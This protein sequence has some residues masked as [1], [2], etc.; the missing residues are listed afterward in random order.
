MS[1]KAGKGGTAFQLPLFSSRV[2]IDAVPEDPRALPALRER[3]A[4]VSFRAP[5]ERFRADPTRPAWKGIHLGTGSGK[6]YQAAQLTLPGIDHG[7]LMIIRTSTIALADQF[8][9]LAKQALG[10]GATV[11]RSLARED[12]FSDDVILRQ[13][14]EALSELALLQR[15]DPRLWSLIAYQYAGRKRAEPKRLEPLLNEARISIERFKASLESLPNSGLD[16]RD[17][18]RLIGRRRQHVIKVFS[19]LLQAVARVELEQPF[20]SKLAPTTGELCSRTFPIDFALF[21]KPGAVVMT[22]SKFQTC[23]VLATRGERRPGGAKSSLPPTHYELL[24]DVNTTH[25]RANVLVI[26][27]EEEGYAADFNRLSSTV[28]SPQTWLQALS[29]LSTFCRWNMFSKASGVVDSWHHLLF[30]RMQA[31]LDHVGAVERIVQRLRAGALKRSEARAELVELLGLTKSP[32][33]EALDGLLDWLETA[34]RR[35]RPQRA[36]E[37]HH[38]QFHGLEYWAL[39]WRSTLMFRAFIRKHGLFSD[40]PTELERWNRF[41]EAVLNRSCLVVTQATLAEVGE[42]LMYLFFDE[43]QRLVEHAMLKH[44]YVAAMLD[45]A[46]L[47]LVYRPGGRQAPDLF[48]LDVLLR[49][50]LWLALVVSHRQFKLPDPSDKSGDEPHQHELRQIHEL[51]KRFT[52]PLPAAKDFDDLLDSLEAGE[53]PVVDDALM[54]EGTKG[55]LTLSTRPQSVHSEE[56]QIALF[57]ASVLVGSPEAQVRTLL[58]ATEGGPSTLGYLMS[59]TSGIGGTFEYDRA[60]LRGALAPV[61]GSFEG[62][63]DTEGEITQALRSRASRDVEVG[64]FEAQNVESRMRVAAGSARRLAELFAVPRECRDYHES[65]FKKDELHV[66]LCALARLAEADGPHAGMVFA[67]SVR[68]VAAALDNAVKTGLS[69]IRRLDGPDD[70]IYE[71]DPRACLLDVSDARPIVVVIYRSALNRSALASQS[72]PE[73]GSELDPEGLDAAGAA[74]PTDE[75]LDKLQRRLD[76]HSDLSR[77]KVLFVSAYLSAARGLSLQAYVDQDGERRPCGYNFLVVANHRYYDRFLRRADARGGSAEQLWAALKHLRHTGELGFMTLSDVGRE[78]CSRPGELL[79]QAAIVE[80]FESHIQA[81]GRLDRGHDLPKLQQIFMSSDCVPDLIE[82]SRLA[83]GFLRR[84]VKPPYVLIKAAEDYALE[85]SPTIADFD[86]HCEREVAV[87]RHFLDG[88]GRWLHGLEEERHRGRS[89][90]FARVWQALRDLDAITDP[91]AF[92]ARLGRADSPLSARDRREF[93][94]YA[95]FDPR[96]FGGEEAQ[97]RTIVVGQ[98]SRGEDIRIVADF[99]N[100]PT[101]T[102]YDPAQQLFDTYLLSRKPRCDYARLCARLELRPEG[103]FRELLPRPLYTTNFLKAIVAEELTRAALREAGV[104]VLSDE[105]A[106]E[107]CVYEYLDV[108]IRL[109]SGRLV[110]ID[111]KH[112]MLGTD[113][114]QKKDLLSRV[115]RKAE[116]VCKRLDEPVTFRYMNLFGGTLR[117]PQRC[118]R[119]DIQFIGLFEKQSG[120]YTS[121]FKDIFDAR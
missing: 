49:L 85:R 62:F 118:D 40:A 99:I 58:N 59:A 88:V 105:W 92:I 83:D 60:Y 4:A 22:H 35:A 28:T 72:L 57:S 74:G 14:P 27:E 104:Q 103:L 91:A 117:P 106:L 112:W 75:E 25:H 89:N 107:H 63:T 69:G 81:T 56:Y 39:C 38:A 54:F 78:L 31:L 93:I 47:E 98:D 1:S 108:F 73:E 79:R 23:P 46:A 29:D 121:S 55:F 95:Y 87:T 116:A 18:G 101:G 34:C 111:S 42:H 64:F 120:N 67:L 3:M 6:T 109:R 96:P 114:R 13:A 30:D 97:F 26:D 9:S 11:Y 41:L 80:H 8:Q 33:R 36:E 84:A 50:L 76:R 17:A 100:A 113:A 24:R 7:S 102:L 119:Y 20:T 70:Q 15:R 66:I 2:V 90:L 16:P 44:I 86:A 10:S 77:N 48:D 115:P 43:R 65:K 61:G 45:H 68:F 94:D 32:R 71:I 110:A 5:L 21:G 19:S 12:Q 82:G 52:V 37:V 51:R 53:D